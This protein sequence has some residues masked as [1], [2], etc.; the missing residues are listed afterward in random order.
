MKSDTIQVLQ[1]QFDSLSQQIPGEDVEFWFARDLQEPLG[2]SKWENFQTAI[3]RAI[4]SCE[5]TGYNPENH[6]RS[7]KKIITHGKGGQ[8]EIDDFMLTRYACYLIAQNGDPRKAPIA[9]AQS[10][11]AIQTRKQE[12]IEDRMRLQA[13]LDARER[14][15]ESEK[16]LSQNIYE[17]GVDDA[18]FG[19][20]RSK[21]DA[22][23][24][25]GHTTQVMKE[26]YGI[27]KTRPLADFLPTLT[28]AAK[29]LATEMTNHNV[30]QENLQGENDI[31]REHIQNNISVRDMLG[32][33]GIKPEKLPPEEDIKKLE[34]RVK[35]EEKK[36]EKQSGRLPEEKGN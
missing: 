1:S 13:R 18:G 23:L 19:R 28:I 29:N 5:T 10:Y 25:G 30:Q 4:E 34:R 36:I 2:Y 16:G 12:L 20:I 17:R 11:F 33:R 7:V 3:K 26:R 22:A 27:T 21:G 6:F 14:L 15:R 32:Q 35:S 8:R 31:T 9:F 24:F